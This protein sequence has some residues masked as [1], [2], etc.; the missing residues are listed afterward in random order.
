MST[1]KFENAESELSCLGA[2]KIILI[3][4]VRRGDNDMLDGLLK[5]DNILLG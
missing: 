5:P 2:S 1:Q 3:D 4:V